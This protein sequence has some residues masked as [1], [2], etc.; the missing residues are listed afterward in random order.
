MEVISFTVRQLYPPGK[1]PSYGSDRRLDVEIN[2]LSALLTRVES[3]TAIES[4][5]EGSNS[6]VNRIAKLESV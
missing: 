1:S 5:S 3:I 2:T 4:C 6:H